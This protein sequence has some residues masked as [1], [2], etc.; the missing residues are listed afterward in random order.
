MQP[1]VSEVQIIPVRPKD[2]LVAFA[3]FVV[4]RAI[5]CTSVAIMTRPLG[6]YRLVYPTK[7]VGE[8]V[9]TVFY[10]ITRTIGSA[11]EEEVIEQ[12]ENVTKGNTNARH[13]SFSSQN[14]RPVES[15]GN[16]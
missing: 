14:Q 1:L 4:Y 12:Y 11:I 6:G 13:D 7:K 3:N 15:D 5:G 9:I 8:Q 10:P 16:R 2:G